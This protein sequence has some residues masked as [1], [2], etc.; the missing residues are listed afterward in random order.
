MIPDD[1]PED[2]IDALPLDDIRT[3]CA[4]GV[5]GPGE[6]LVNE[7]LELIGAAA[8]GAAVK[9]PAKRLWREWLDYMGNPG[10]DDL[11]DTDLPIMVRAP[12]TAAVQDILGPENRF[13]ASNVADTAYKG[14]PDTDLIPG[15]N[16]RRLMKFIAWTRKAES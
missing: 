4:S 15:D 1:I 6:Q 10:P 11:A 16:I 7:T 13:A 9:R 5:F 14:T 12:C 8:T 3:M 2:Q